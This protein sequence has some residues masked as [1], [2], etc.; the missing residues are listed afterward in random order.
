MEAIN[1]IRK[2]VAKG[3]RKRMYPLALGILLGAICAGVAMVAGLD[4]AR[5]SSVVLLIAIAIFYVVFAVEAGANLVSQSLI[6]ST[7]VLVAL[8][9]YRTSLWGIA[10]GLA[11]HALYDAFSHTLGAPAPH[12][13]PMFCLG[14]DLVLA[15]AVATWIATG[16]LEVRAPS[17]AQ[18]D[19]VNIRSG[20]Q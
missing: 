8:V 7:F 6:A 2:Y 18:W 4:R 12:W 15:C 1:E 13:W 11:T 17:R 20:G 3:T 14:F 19:N 16:R 10:I 5:A 9:S